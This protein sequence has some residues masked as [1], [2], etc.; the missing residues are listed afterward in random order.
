MSETSL[1]SSSSGQELEAKAEWLRNRVIDALERVNRRVTRNRVWATVL[2]GF[3]LTFSIL[4]TIFLGLQYESLRNA[5][6]ILITLNTLT[7]LIEPFFNFRGL[8]I[9]HER[10]EYKFHILRDDLDYYLI[11]TDSSELSLE[12]LNYFQK[13]FQQIWSD[14]SESWLEQRQSQ[15][16]NL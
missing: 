12:K 5:A 3:S 11:G 15:R 7:F 14:L 1:N 13:R 8:W 2:K 6:F 16:F 4:A 9:E 10:A